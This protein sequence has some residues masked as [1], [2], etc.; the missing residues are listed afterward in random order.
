MSDNLSPY[1]SSQ[2]EEGMQKTM[3][4]YEAIYSETINLISFLKPDVKRWLDTG[5][6]TGSLITRVFPVFEGTKY[7]LA[8]PSEQMLDKAQQSLSSIP[9]DHLEIVGSIGTENLPENFANSLQVVTAI[10]AHHYFQRKG[11]EIATKKC[12]QLLETGGVYIT[13]ENIYPSTEEAKEIGLRRWKQFQMSKGKSEAQANSH[14]SRFNKSFFPVTVDE[15]LK[16]LKDSGFRMA[17][18][19][20]Y[21]NMQAGFYAIK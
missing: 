3:P 12:Y 16:I 20:W 14:I 2:Y 9:S 19:F 4:F 13:F 8:D 18:L 1:S 17:E 5:C 15:H 6:G 11:R 7:F 21:S 10:L